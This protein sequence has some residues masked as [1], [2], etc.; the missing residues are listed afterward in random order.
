MDFPKTPVMIHKT[1]LFKLPWRPSR[2]FCLSAQ[3]KLKITL[4]KFLSLL[5]IA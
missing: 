1:K 2:I 5:N 3:L 4:M